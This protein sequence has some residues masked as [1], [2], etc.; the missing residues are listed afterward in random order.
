M[1]IKVEKISKIFGKTRVLKDVS[2]AVKEGEFVALLGPSGSGK[3]TILYTIAGIYK[4]TSGRIFFNGKDVTGL[5]P[6][7][8]N[9]GMVFQ[10]WALY[11]H[12]TVFENIAYPL[13]IKKL[14]GKEIKEKVFRVSEMLRIE[15]L[16]DRYPG[17]L[18]GG[19]QQRVSIARALVKEPSVL[20]FDEPLSNLDTL[21]RIEI[22]SE[23]KKLQKDLKI[24]SLYVTHDQTEA[25][26]LADK[27][28]LIDRGEIVQVGTPEEVYYKPKNT[29]V[30]EFFGNPVMN[31]LE[32]KIEGNELIV[33]ET[34]RIPFPERKNVQALTGKKVLIGFRAY[35]V[36]LEKNGQIEGK[37]FS[38]EPQ[39]REVFLTVEVK[40]KHIKVLT[41]EET[42]K[43]ISDHRISFSLPFEKIF[44]FDFATR[45]RLELE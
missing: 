37:L 3:S 17:E 40:R 21:L 10:N 38:I 31:F 9:V 7:K 18:S 6:K 1:D 34:W 22:R 16:L 26:A 8:R 15:K 28:I 45:R 29:F 39:G 41:N 32:G 35:D 30:A 23:I 42:L 33:E 43:E 44:L 4:P 14:P 24:T 20:L 27:I 13:K 2:F 5:P 11:P 36:R 12:M 25:M 19:Q